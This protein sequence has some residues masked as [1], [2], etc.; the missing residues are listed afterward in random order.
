MVTAPLYHTCVLGRI[1]CDVVRLPW[2]VG[3]AKTFCMPARHIGRSAWIWEGGRAGR[4]PSLTFLRSSAD[5]TW[6]VLY[7]PNNV[8]LKELLSIRVL[9]VTV[10]PG[11]VIV[12][13][14]VLPGVGLVPGVRVVPGVR[15]V[16]SVVTV[17][18]LGPRGRAPWKLTI[19]ASLYLI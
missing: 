1:V 14:G 8:S 7:S 11:V 10:V 18:P 4:V 17:V 2:A 9:V 15:A 13:G 16:I 6:E 12:D 19:P 5:F 3:V